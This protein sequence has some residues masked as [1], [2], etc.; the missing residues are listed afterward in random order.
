MYVSK[1]IFCTIIQSDSVTRGPKLLS[2]N[3]LGP[4]ATES[5]CTCVQI[6]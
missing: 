1:E 6:M 3:S 5:P 4:L 2:I